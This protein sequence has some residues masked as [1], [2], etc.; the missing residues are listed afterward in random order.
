MA[1]HPRSATSRSRAT[2]PGRR[3]RRPRLVRAYVGL[4]ANLGDAAGTLAAS[5]HAL[6]A[7]PGARLAGVSRLYATAPV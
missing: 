6:A 7:L 3:P 2:T 1:P 4:G 5:V